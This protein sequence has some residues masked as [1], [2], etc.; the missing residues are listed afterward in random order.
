MNLKLDKIRQFV[1]NRKVNL[2]KGIKTEEVNLNILIIII[3]KI[4]MKWVAEPSSAFR[5]FTAISSIPKV[6][7][8]NALH[9]MPWKE[10]TILKPA[11]FLSKYENN[12]EKLF[13]ILQKSLLFK[14][15]G[16]HRKLLV[17]KILCSFYY[18]LKNTEQ[19]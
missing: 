2:Y 16:A 11:T 9:E 18:L 1:R 15:L 5:I 3:K 13:R 19:L 12:K 17:S 10:L 14:V 4:N 8:I 6:I 7:H